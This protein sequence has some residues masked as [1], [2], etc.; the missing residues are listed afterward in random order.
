[1][2]KGDQLA[3]CDALGVEALAERLIA[4]ETQTGIAVSIG[5]SQATL[6]NWIALDPERSARTREARIASAAS[7]SDKAE[8][9]LSEATDPFELSKARELAS[10]YRWKASK[11]DPRQFGD[12][13][14]I[15]QR[16]TLTDLTE[17]QIDAKLAR[18]FKQSGEAGADRTA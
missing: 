16:T 6:I 3:K 15:D 5:V 1:M 18:L 8:Q 17:E 9:V 11:T 10:H 13:I 12:K 4:G 2:A 7:Y 14:E